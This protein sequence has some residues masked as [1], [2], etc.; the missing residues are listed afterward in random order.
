M[1]E[2]PVVKIQTQFFI[3]QVSRNKKRLIKNRILETGTRQEIEN[4]ELSYFRISRN[5]RAMKWCLEDEIAVRKNIFWME[6]QRVYNEERDKEID[7]GMKQS[8]EYQLFY[9]SIFHTIG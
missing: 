2:C 6:K 5:D 8:E 7:I 3:P 1:H 4:A 9:L